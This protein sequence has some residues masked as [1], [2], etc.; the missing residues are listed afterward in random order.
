MYCCRQIVIVFISDSGS[1]MFLP[2]LLIS[3][4]DK[5]SNLVNVRLLRSHFSLYF[6]FM[7]SPYI[8]FIFQLKFIDVYQDGQPFDFEKKKK[9]LCKL[10]QLRS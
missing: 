4:A 1:S 2:L 9:N 8:L 10:V 7:C 3:F 6:I 5:P